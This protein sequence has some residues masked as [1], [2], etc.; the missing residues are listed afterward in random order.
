MPWGLG[1]SAKRISED[2]LLGEKG[3]HFVA[4]RFLDM[5]F[6]WH[7]TN[8]P[9][10]AGIDGHVEIRDPQTGAMSNVWL[11]VQVKARTK[12]SAENAESF[13]FRCTSRDLEYWRRGNMPVLLV[14]VRP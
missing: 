11:A 8:A 10:D 3:V 2:Q 1:T 7:P 12:L 9:L 6:L 14:V 5:G 4:S 13:E